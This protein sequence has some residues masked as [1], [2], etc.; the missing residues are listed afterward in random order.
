[1]CGVAGILHFGRSD[2]VTSNILHKMNNAMLHRGPD[3]DGIYISKNRRIG[4]GHRRLSIIDLSEGASQPMSNGDGSV[5][6]SYNGEIYNHQLLRSQL[7]T[8]GY[9]F[10]S[11]HSDTEVLVH[12]YEAWGI[13]TLLEKIDGMFAFIIW[14]EKKKS[15]YFCPRSD[16]Y[17]A[18]LF[19]EKLGRIGNCI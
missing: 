7:E 12:G 19:Y 9:H 8:R 5:W 11:H 2:P 1:M 6:I 14:D 13:A 15:T 18:N 17:K 16:R 4:L 10:H 3:G